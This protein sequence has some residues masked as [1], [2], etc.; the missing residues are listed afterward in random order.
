LAARRTSPLLASAM[1]P[2]SS[3]A[4]NTARN[5]SRSSGRIAVLTSHAER[6]KR[7]GR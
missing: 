3:R 2:T 6:W 1:S 5:R 4:S 7:R